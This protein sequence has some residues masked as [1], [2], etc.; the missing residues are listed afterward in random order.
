[1]LTEAV[2]LLKS[3]IVKDVPRCRSGDP[4]AIRWF[5]RV[6]HLAAFLVYPQDLF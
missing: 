4:V 1:M 3:V 6:L 5:A 2:V